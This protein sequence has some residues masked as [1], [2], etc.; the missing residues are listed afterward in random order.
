MTASN[1]PLY[2]STDRHATWLEL[3]FDLVFVAVI[4]A[5][6][7]D[8]AHTHE[9]HISAEQ[10]LRF[11]LVFI[12]VWWIWMS[13]TLYANRFDRDD[14]WHRFIT[15]MIMAGVVLMSTFSAASLKGDFSEYAATYIT[16]RLVLAAMYYG[17]YRREQP[18]QLWV[19][20]VAGIITLGALVSGVAMALEGEARFFVFYLGIALDI[21]WQAYVRGRTEQHQVDRAHLV[22]RV[23]LMIII[24]LGESII[25]IVGSLS[26]VDWT[27]L[28][29]A[30]AIGGFAFIWGF[31]WIYYDSFPLLERARRLSSGN[32]LAL[33]H[34]FLCMGLLLLANMIRHTILNDLDRPTFALFA[35]TGMMAFYLGKQMP[36]WQVFPPWRAGILFNSLVCIGITVGSVFLPNIQLALLGMCSGIAV[37]LLLSFRM[38]QSCPVDD[39]LVQH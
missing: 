32:L 11:P 12:P 30:S 14:R 24:L 27:P 3:F 17:A 16:V 9:G 25:A 33:S 18:Q 15:L 31:W 36:Y 35:I 7:H 28:R 39:Y 21:G 6:T 1:P 10:L 13:H 5:V 34:L 19:R 8:L 29:V 4:G 37:Y 2:L 26:E 20:E 38:L 22:E 23:G